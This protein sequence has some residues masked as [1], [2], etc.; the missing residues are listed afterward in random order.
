[1]IMADKIFPG[2]IR[3]SEEGRMN[4]RRKSQESGQVLVVLAVALVALLG[5]TALAIDV[6][7]VYSD[8]RYD[9]N[10][11]DAAAL[12]GGNAALKAMSANL[13]TWENFDCNMAANTW[14]PGG[15]GAPGWLAGSSN[16]IFTAA[17]SRAATNNKTIDT[18]ISDQNGVVL[19]CG[20]DYRDKYIDIRV[21][22]SGVTRTSF[23]QLLFG[24]SMRNTVEAVARVRPTTP[25]ATGYAVYATDAKCDGNGVLSDGGIELSIDGGGIFS[26]SCF[27]GQ[28]SFDVKVTNGTNN[29]L[30]PYVYQK[31]GGSG[32]ISPPPS[33]VPRSSFVYKP[34]EPDC[35]KVPNSPSSGTV[36]DPG[37]YDGTFFKNGDFK[38]RAGLYCISGDIDLN[39]G[40]TIT[41]IENGAGLLGVTL[42]FKDGGI[43][44]NGNAYMSVEAAN[45]DGPAPA[46]VVRGVVIFSAYGNT[47]GFTLLGNSLSN[48]TGTVY[49]PDGE[50]EVGGT[51]DVTPPTWTTQLIAKDF[52]MHGDGVVNIQYNSQK[53]A[54]VPPS[55]ELSK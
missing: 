23:A 30:A 15:G 12:A 19:R 17:I 11:A 36:L 38:L 43:K 35:S 37:N 8:R 45:M 2:K 21:E 26:K 16:Q 33:Q 34:K 46:N 50:I 55:L 29:M 40:E 28:G 5:F 49:V 13:I 27:Q 7:M 22:V 48:Y 20:S 9:Q 47:S 4:T 54:K 1:M 31:D 53:C 42:F 44:A 41:S 6:G 52:W 39:G 3:D 24:G 32:T 14:I 10:V 25:M 18:D 51:S